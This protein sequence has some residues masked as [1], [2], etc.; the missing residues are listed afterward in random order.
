MKKFVRIIDNQGYFIEDAFVEEL[1]EFTIEEPCQG[2]FYR[3]KWNGSKWTEG[4]SVAEINSLKGVQ[5]PTSI[6]MRQT[7]LALLSKGLLDVVENAITN[8]NDKAAEIEWQNSSVVERNNLLVNNMC[9]ALGMSNEEIDE[10][11]IFANTL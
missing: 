11:F 3:P 1:T 7:K 8:M 6:T 5:L 10:F 4:L 2:G 9:S